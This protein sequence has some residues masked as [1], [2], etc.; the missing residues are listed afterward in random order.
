MDRVF[1]LKTF[2][3]QIGVYSDVIIDHPKNIVNVKET[4]FP[5]VL[6]CASIGLKNIISYSD[7]IDWFVDFVHNSN[8]FIMR[9]IHIIC[10]V[11]NTLQIYNIFL[12]FWYELTFIYSFQ[13]IMTISQKQMHQKKNV[14]KFYANFVS[15]ILHLGIFS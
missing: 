4:M 7:N 14:L 2:V 9:F 5:Q 10:Q 15:I 13:A 12:V 8:L 6:F 3:I 1:F 11:W